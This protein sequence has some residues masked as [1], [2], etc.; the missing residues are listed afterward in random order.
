M[1][2][3]LLEKFKKILTIGNNGKQNVHTILLK[4]YNSN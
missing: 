2:L 1:L 3:L 4:M